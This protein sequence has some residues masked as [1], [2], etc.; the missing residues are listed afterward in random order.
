MNSIT[1][2]SLKT[3]LYSLAFSLFIIILFLFLKMLF[4]E[5]HVLEVK[6][7]ESNTSKQVQSIQNNSP[8]DEKNKESKL[9]LLPSK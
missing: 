4:Q 7:F 5:S 9:F 6:S 1:P 3:L 8:K 2:K